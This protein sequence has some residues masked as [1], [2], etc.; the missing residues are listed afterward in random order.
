MTAVTQAVKNNDIATVVRPD[1]KTM[2]ARNASG[3]AHIQ[4]RTPR[5]RGSLS[6]NARSKFFFVMVLG[7]GAE[8]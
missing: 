3:S 7:Y 6:I 4:R 5:N 8:K 2:K 1:E